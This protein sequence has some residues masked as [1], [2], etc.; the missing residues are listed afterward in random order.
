[1]NKANQLFDLSSAN[2]L[3]L[4]GSSG[5]GKAIA[6]AFIANGANVCIASI[7]KPGLQQTQNEFNE[8]YQRAST[9]FYVDVTKND[10][11]IDLRKNVSDAFSNELHILVHSVGTTKR[12]PIT[13]IS[14][15]E[16]E[17]IHAINS[18]SAFLVAKQFYP[19]LKQASFGRLIN[20][21]SYFASHASANRLSYA[22]SKGALLQLTRVLAAEWANDDITVN[23]ISPGGFLTPLTEKLLSDPE[24]VANIERNIPMGRLGSTDELMTAA[25]F[26]AS[27]L[28]SYVTGQDIIVDGGWSVL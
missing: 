18:T 23:S 2:A 6:E 3:V 26:F 11:I 10:S 24:V 15:S 20:I 1:M 14:L 12:T 9:T 27:P 22:S 16:W 17:S 21:A 8:K 7:D 19:L 13:E 25:M 28:S 5:I 4:G